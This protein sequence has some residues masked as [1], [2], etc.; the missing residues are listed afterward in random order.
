MAKMLGVFFRSD[1]NV[2]KLQRGMVA[3]AVSIL[4]ATELHTVKRF[5][6]CCVDCTSKNNAVRIP[7]TLKAIRI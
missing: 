5:I 1:E 6:V 2:L 4:N 7:L 3:N